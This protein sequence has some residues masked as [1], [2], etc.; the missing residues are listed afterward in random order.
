MPKRKV[1][2]LSKNS[3]QAK[4]I[5]KRR[6]EETNVMNQARLQDSQQRWVAA[7]LQNKQKRTATV[8][9][10]LTP[11][12]RKKIK[13]A[14]RVR[15]AAKRQEDTDE[16]C[17]ARKKANQ[18]QM[19][20]AR[21]AENSK[22][23]QIR[24]QTTKERN[25]RTMMAK[26][27]Q[28]QH[29]WQQEPH[30]E[31]T[32]RMAEIPQKCQAKQQAVMEDEETSMEVSH[33]AELSSQQDGQ[34]LSENTTDEILNHRNEDINDLIAMMT[35][36]VAGELVMPQHE[37]DHTLNDVEGR[38]LPDPVE[39]IFLRSFQDSFQ[40]LDDEEPGDIHNQNEVYHRQVI[41]ETDFTPISDSE[42][43]ERGGPSNIQNQY[44][45]NT[46]EIPA[47]HL[48]PSSQSERD[49]QQRQTVEINLPRRSSRL[50][51]IPQQQQPPI[52]RRQR[53]IRLFDIARYTDVDYFN[54]QEVLSKFP[55]HYGG[56]LYDNCCM[57]CKA[58]RW[59][60]E[61]GSMCCK[62]GKVSLPH[63]QNP[64]EAIQALY[65][66]NYFLDKLVWYNNALSLTSLG[67]KKAAIKGF[68][69]IFKIQG[70]MY[71]QIGSLLPPEG[72]APKFAQIYMYDTEHEIQYRLG[73]TDLDEV[74][75]TMLQENLHEYNS[76]VKSFKAAS[77]LVTSDVKIVLHHK[78][79]LRPSEAH[80][81]TYNLP[82]SSEVAALVTEESAGDRDLI[83]S[84]RDGSMKRV[85]ALHRSYDPLQYVLMFPYGE[86]GWE[87]DM[88]RNNNQMKLSPMDFYSYRLQV[89]K[90]DFNTV[91]RCRRLMQTY[92]V[93]M[94]CK[95]EGARLY[96]ARTHQKEIRAEKYSGL[97]DAIAQNDLQN[98][99][100]K[101][102]LPS[103]IYGSP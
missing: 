60:N 96:W 103:T 4:L 23:R 25:A 73:N 52:I 92:A 12:Q 14:D 43:D 87:L 9:K 71:H 29:L 34:I 8:R 6:E 76:Y 2:N 18:M 54:E 102:I 15:N 47:Q 69:P 80:C 26:S 55:Q 99:G 10:A 67:C 35:Q 57:H 30:Q 7:R 82:L 17:Q 36:D 78:K 65:E 101:I 53:R 24:Q 83:L 51:A 48:S 37:N 45:A 41:S 64:P 1:S 100:Q 62:N 63:L 97:L 66:N 42:R 46:R 40:D 28:Q 94:W 98:T 75:M 93:D 5:C 74:T 33:H 22:Q 59:N 44:E 89:R 11:Q 81:R 84:A 58:Y 61:S 50:A 3:K 49:E 16:E 13:H 38:I 19:A 27:L 95:I 68:S 56:S 79:A 90:D 70:K 77:E 86:D 32:A 31:G 20:K 72:F 85:S 39:E 21:M 88:L 91:M